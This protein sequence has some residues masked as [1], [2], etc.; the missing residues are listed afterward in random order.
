[1][2]REARQYELVALKEIA[3]ILNSMNEMKPMLDQVL[4]KLLEVT[5]FSAGWIFIMDEPGADAGRAFCQLPEAL[6][7]NGQA[8]MRGRE[9]G[10]MEGFRQGTLKQAVNIIECSRIA[11][12]VSNQLGDTQGISHHATVPL[13]AGGDAFGLLNVAEA[14]RERFT[15]EELELLQAVAYQIGTAIKRIRLYQAQETRAGL[16]A[17][18]NHVIQ[19]LN[20]LQDMQ[21][22]PAKAVQCIGETFGWQQVSLF[23]EDDLRLSLR[24]SYVNGHVREEA[25]SLSQDE[26]GPVGAAFREKRL[27]LRSDEKCSEHRNGSQGEQVRY[28][29]AAAIPLLHQGGLI[30]VLFVSSNP[31]RELSGSHEDFLYSL[32]SHFALCV[33]NLRGDARQR[34][35]ARLEERNRMALDLHDSV[36]QKLFSISFMARGIESQASEASAQMKQPLSEISRLASDTLKEMRSLIW[37]LRPAGLEHGLL[38]ALKQYG[39]HVGLQV[40]EQALGVRELP[41]QVEEALWRIGQEALNNVSKHAGTKAAW[42]TLTKS[43]QEAVLEVVD[44]GVGFQV[45]TL[46]GRMTMGLTS[47]RERAQRL[48]GSLS[49]EHGPA[50]ATHITARI[51]LPSPANG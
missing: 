48:G 3:E 46:K 37:Q 26:A 19:Q 31:G 36:V 17:K 50:A 18:L 43:G 45:D 33:D 32:G 39:Q 9:C 4:H 47:M 15:V 8:A 20:G 51:P 12:A 2:T 28:G 34:D 38:P 10:C 40:H 13:R 49:I 11:Y 41:R 16:Y 21:R 24:A 14:G 7:A 22:L 27:V 42:I 1:M 44:H 35:L 25:R 30:G 29:A 5:R 23:I 6:D